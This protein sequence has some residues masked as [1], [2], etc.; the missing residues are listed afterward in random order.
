MEKK[1]IKSHVKG[2]KQTGKTKWA[3]IIS[4]KPIVDNENPD[5][6][7]KKEFIKPGEG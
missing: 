7:Y 4:N 5:L 3:K 6:A 1:V 2:Q